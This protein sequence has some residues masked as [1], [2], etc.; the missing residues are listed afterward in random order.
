MEFWMWADGETDNGQLDNC[1]EQTIDT[2]MELPGFA[3][4]LLDA[5]WLAKDGSGLT[6]PNWEHHLG[7]GAKQRMIAARRVQRHRVRRA[8]ERNAERQDR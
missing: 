5:G 1:D 8:N 7:A 2:I 3:D 4:A 6:I